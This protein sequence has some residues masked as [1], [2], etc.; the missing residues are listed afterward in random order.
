L[1]TSNSPPPSSKTGVNGSGGSGKQNAASAIYGNNAN[2]IN[3]CDEEDMLDLTGWQC[4][5]EDCLQMTS[6]Q[7]RF[8]SGCDRYVCEDTL[9]LML[10]FEREDRG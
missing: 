8:C 6:S 3:L 2:I 9:N 5:Y 1:A 7:T 10:K 4:P